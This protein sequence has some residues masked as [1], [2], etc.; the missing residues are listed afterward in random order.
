MVFIIKR[1]IKLLN[2]ENIINFIYNLD[3][4]SNKMGFEN[5]DI[6]N[7]EEL[8]DE[9]LKPLNNEFLRHL[10]EKRPLYIALSVY[11]FTNLKNLKEISYENNKHISIVK[12]GEI[13]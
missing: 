13:I 6:G 5:F 11:F 8:I 3:I 4:K 1:H 9:L 12:K 7:E 10:D 2:N